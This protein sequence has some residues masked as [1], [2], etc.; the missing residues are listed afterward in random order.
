MK[1]LAMAEKRLTRGLNR[2]A[3]TA[4]QSKGEGAKAEIIHPRAEL[5]GSDRL[6][7]G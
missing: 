3:A 6:G 1:V 5:L 2:K 7:E 4:G